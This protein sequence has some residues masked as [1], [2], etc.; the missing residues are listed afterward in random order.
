MATTAIIVEML[1]IGF[2]ACVWILLM[3]VHW[4]GIDATALFKEFSTL[5]GWST[6]L[7]L[8]A[9]A[10]FYQVGWTVNWISASITALLSEQRVRNRIFLADELEYQNVR[11]VINQLGSTALHGELNA[12][13]SVIRLAR[14]GAMNFL[15]TAIAVLQFDELLLGALLLIC[16]IVS[17]WQWR[18]RYMRYYRAIL[19]AYKVIQQTRAT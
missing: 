7:T 14:S 4:L 10:V 16:S 13:R 3:I 12:E 5:S 6:P 11:A 15:L 19:A 1:I 2:F 18:K 9:T 8:A 17:G